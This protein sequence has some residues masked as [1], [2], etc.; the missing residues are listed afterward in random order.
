MFY[1]KTNLKFFK[2]C[3]ILG[4]VEMGYNFIQ[5]TTL[6]IHIILYRSR[7]SFEK[8]IIQL[9]YCTYIFT[10]YVYS[11]SVKL[12]SVLFKYDMPRNKFMLIGDFL[13][14]IIVL[15]SHFRRN[16]ISLKNTA[17]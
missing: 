1:Y 14:R 17:G 8:N 6:N 9:Y 12:I 3:G 13:G 10:F 5:D 4:E 7:Q 15:L 11:V 2:T 16:K